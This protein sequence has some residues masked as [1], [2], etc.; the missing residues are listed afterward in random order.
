M[1]YT[2]S[3][4]AN[5]ISPYLGSNKPHGLSTALLELGFQASVVDSSLFIFFH[6]NIKKKIACLCWR[7]Y[8]HRDWFI[9][10]T[11][12]YLSTTEAISIKGSWQSWI[13][14]GIQAHRTPDSLHLC[15]AKYVADLL[16][17][18]GMLGSKAARSPCSSGLKLSNF[19]GKRLV[20]PSEYRFVVG[21]LQYCTLTRLD[22]SFAVNQLCQHLQ[23][24]TTTHW[25]AAK[26]VLLYLK[27]TAN[28]G[29][30]YSKGPLQLQAFCDFDWAGNP[31]DRRST[32]GFRIFLGNCLVSW[33]AKKT[34]H[35][36]SVKYWGRI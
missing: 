22:L 26:C 27:N 28:H 4:C 31:D 5:F 9:G 32:F 21:A 17:R 13:F 34:T 24:P 36:L 10:D 2:L 3:L 18:T 6:K 15:H 8:C 23:A 11:I 14:L 7:F 1:A 33:S 16:H 20:D 35:G 19:D 12:S 25:T 29:L 30:L